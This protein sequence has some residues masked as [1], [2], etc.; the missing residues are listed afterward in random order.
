M[1]RTPAFWR[2]RG[3]LA[4]LLSPCGAFYL[5]GGKIRQAR[6]RPQA[7]PIPV[8]CIGNAV[9]GGSGKT[10]VVRA[11]A[12][13]LQAAGHR[14]HILSRGYGGKA[15]GAM[16]R[17]VQTTDHSADVGDEPL[18]LAATA[19]VWVSPNRLASAKAAADADADADAAIMDDGWQSTAL[20]KDINL[21]VLDGAYG[22]GNGFGLPAGPLRECWPAALARA[23]AVVLYGQDAHGLLQGSDLPVFRAALAADREGDWHG[24]RLLAFAGIG[25]PEK[26]FATLENL[27]AQ[28]V[29]QRAF[30]DHHP[31]DAEEIRALTERAQALDATL[32]TTEKDWARMGRPEAVAYLPVR[33]RWEDEAGLRRWLLA[34]LAAAK[35]SL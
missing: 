4:W 12:E 21:L 28:M 10:P 23:D 30:P 1:L 27:G 17:R 31:Y 15:V 14:P 35:T 33:C 24:R 22:I 3:P 9:V 5:I 32:A 8:I 19:P 34:R 25:R 11:L 2:R 6:G 7:A 18:M 16:P 26:F 13:M 29:E 20:R